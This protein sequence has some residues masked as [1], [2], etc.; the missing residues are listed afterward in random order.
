MLTGQPT[1]PIQPVFQ[2]ACAVTKALRKA[3]TAC[4]VAPGSRA[5]VYFLRAD[6][7][8]ELHYAMFFDMRSTQG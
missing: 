1:L 5:F 3:M 8:D 4:D 7:T 2:G 6:E